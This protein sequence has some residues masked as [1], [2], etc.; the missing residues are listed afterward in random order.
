MIAVLALYFEEKNKINKGKIKAYSDSYLQ[1]LLVL[2]LPLSY[3]LV[4]G[5]G[6]SLRFSAAT[7][8]NAQLGQLVTHGAVECSEVLRDGSLPPSILS[9]H[10]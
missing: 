3:V 4:E 10:C 7:G 8:A 2:T 5:D 9:F 1:Q 6:D